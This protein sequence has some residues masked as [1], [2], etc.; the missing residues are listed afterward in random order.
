VQKQFELSV[1][2]IH[3]INFFEG[4]DCVAQA[5]HNVGEYDLSDDEIENGDDSLKAVLWMVVSETDSAK[6][7]AN[8]VKDCYALF[9]SCLVLQF[10]VSDKVASFITICWNFISRDFKD[11]PADQRKEARATECY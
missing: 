5:V 11:N 2:F 8:P 7:S 1:F 6:C 9:V 4:V 3:V 10:I